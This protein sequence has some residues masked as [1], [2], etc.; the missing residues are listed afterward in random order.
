MALAMSDVTDLA[1]CWELR[2][3]TQLGQIWR[4]SGPHR[5]L[6]RT[7]AF[8]LTSVGAGWEQARNAISSFGRPRCSRAR[9]THRRCSWNQAGLQLGWQL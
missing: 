3:R 8:S 4:L 1:S 5:Q 6:Q 2:T 7:F 9:R